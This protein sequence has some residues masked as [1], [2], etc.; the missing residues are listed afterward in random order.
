MLAHIGT[1]VART[2]LTHC[3]T[4]ARGSIHPAGAKYGCPTI[5]KIGRGS[6]CGSA[7]QDALGQLVKSVKPLCYAFT[8]LEPKC[9][10]RTM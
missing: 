8:S 10:L 4:V 2:A 3:K 6:N 5:W 9:G 1:E 7:R